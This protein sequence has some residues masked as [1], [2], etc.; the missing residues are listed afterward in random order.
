MVSSVP[1]A[2]NPVTTIWS[3]A[4]P[5]LARQLQHF[6]CPLPIGS[7]SVG[8]F[9]P[10]L[11]VSREI[12]R[13][14]LGKSV[15]RIRNKLNVS[16][17]LMVFASLATG[18]L[19]AQ[20][21]NG[22][23]ETGTL[24]GWTL[25][26]QVHVAVVQSANFNP[27]PVAA[28]EGTHFAAI[29]TGPGQLSNTTY[30]VD[31]NGANEFDMSSMQQTVTFTSTS[32]PAMLLFSWNFPSSEQDQPTQF[33]D[34]FDVQ[35]TIGATTSR[36]FSGSACKNDGS[37]FSPFPNVAC[38]GS[39]LLNW[40]IVNAAPITNTS[41][42]Y[43]VGPWQ[44]AC[45]AIPGTVIGSNTVTITVRAADQSDNQFDSALLVDNF[46][47]QPNCNSAATTLQQIT[48]SNG[49]NVQVKNGG[50]VFTP[51]DNGPPLSADNTGTAFAFASTG[52]YTGDNPNALQQIFVYDN[53]SYTR[54]TGLTIASG[55]Q[56]EGVSLSGPLVGSLH[57]RY[58]AIAATLNAAASQQIYRWDRQTSTLTQV[59]NTTGCANKNPSISGD[60]SRI[61]W[62]TT[63]NAFTG[64]GTTQKV[65]YGT[66]AATWSAPVNFM[67]TGT[68]A[69]SCK[70]FEPHLSRGDTGNFI[71]LRSTC[72]LTG[73]TPVAT[74]GD[75]FR[76]NISAA[77]WLRAATTETLATTNNFGPSID[78]ATAGNA[79][80]YVYFISDG[81]YF[82]VTND[83][84]LE[85]YRYDFNTSTLKQ[86]TTT[87]A[88]SG[89]ISVHQASDGTGALFSYEF[90][91]GSTNRFEDGTGNFNGTTLTLKL[92]ATMALSLNADVGVD[93]G[94]VPTVL[95]LSNDDLKSPSQNADGNT[96]VYSA[97]TP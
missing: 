38:S 94:N 84:Q 87:Q 32:S 4:T 30:D 5:P 43:G 56:V 89:Y 13:N 21:V 10:I 81:N 46:T 9:V 29:S 60:G 86:I 20:L 76:Y 67:S 58:V 16:F 52:N 48:S 79:G 3:C 36:V 71:A 68:P 6:R 54:V 34:V 95:F 75:I 11:R 50:V 73:T 74:L 51:V 88:G 90:V 97:R 55:G 1:T 69:A 59:T 44:Q 65:V 70:G 47:I 62:E 2:S 91:N 78:A 61:A 66:F 93:A 82:N 96:E 33:D 23:F 7:S 12:N 40:T 18:N 26:G 72:N 92:G 83:T 85:I 25:G 24:A 31:G 45:V 63:C 28:P 57:G 19:H 53:S 80:R 49:A 22:G 77:T 14:R 8:I 42:R 27:G 15:H 17:A 39:T 64:Q 35:T 41:L 37:S